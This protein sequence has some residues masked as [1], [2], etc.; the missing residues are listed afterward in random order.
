[1]V[2]K[3]DREFRRGRSLRDRLRTGGAPRHKFN[4]NLSFGFEYYADFG[5]IGHFLPL[6]QRPYNLFAVT[7]FK[8]GDF[9]ID[10]GVGHGFTSGS[11]RLIFKAIV[12]YSFPC[13]ILPRSF[14]V[15]YLGRI[16]PRPGLLNLERLL[17]CGLAHHADSR[18]IASFRVPLLLA[19]SGS[20]LAHFRKISPAF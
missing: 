17:L 14:S 11:D 12:G 5:Q 15:I 13:R 9:D 20:D 7:Y 16:R 2:R 8:V 6:Q 19:S 3:S 1:M 18:S 10:F 4:K